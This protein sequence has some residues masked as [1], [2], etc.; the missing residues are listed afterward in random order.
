MF[1]ADVTEK[2]NKMIAADVEHESAIEK[3]RNKLRTSESCNTKYVEAGLGDR[4]RQ[5]WDENEAGDSN[6]ASTNCGEEEDPRPRRVLNKECTD[7]QS[8]YYYIKT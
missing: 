3:R 4:F 1:D 8:K 2:M 5:I 6:N 7:D